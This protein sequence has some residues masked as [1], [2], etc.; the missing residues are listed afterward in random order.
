MVRELLTH[1]EEIAYKSETNVTEDQVDVE[2]LLAFI[3]WLDMTG[4]NSQVQNC[5][6]AL[7]RKFKQ[8]GSD[9]LTANFRVKEVVRGLKLEKAQDH[10][11]P[12]P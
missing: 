11:A 8:S 2:T 6:S 3:G 4:Q 5:L 1:A 7:S 12:W 9:D 10:E